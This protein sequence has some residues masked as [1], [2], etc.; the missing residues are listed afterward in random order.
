[1]KFFYDIT[2]D[3]HGFYP[4]DAITKLDKVILDNDNSSI[5]VIHGCG[6]GI[7]RK[8]IRNYCE[9]CNYIKSYDNGENL[10]IPGGDGVT[11]VYTT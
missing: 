9:I 7:L 8:T 5:M 1:M 4:D 10:N 6:E 2:L 11:I 3:L